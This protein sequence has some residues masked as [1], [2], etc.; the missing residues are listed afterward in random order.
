M[1]DRLILFQ[2]ET[3]NNYN[4]ESTRRKGPRTDLPRATRRKYPISSAPMRKITRHSRLNHSIQL[5]AAPV[6]FTD[7]VFEALD[8]QMRS[9]QIHR[10]TVF[11]TMRERISDPRA[12]KTLIRKI[13]ENYHLPMSP[14]PNLQHLSVSWLS[15]RRIEVCPSCQEPCEIYSRCRYLRPIKQWN[16]GKKEEFKLRKVYNF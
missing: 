3:G 13:C 7:D 11:H 5:Y 8:L 2:K 16:R 10:R 4:L 9:R 14:L 15:K 12:V 1:R 6:N